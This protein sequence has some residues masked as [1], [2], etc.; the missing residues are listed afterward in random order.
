MLEHDRREAAGAAE[1]LARELGALY[2]GLAAHELSPLGEGGDFRTWLVRGS[3][4]IRLAKGPGAR[5]R[6]RNEILILPRLCR[7]VPVQVPDI[8]L[9]GI[10]PGEPGLPRFIRYERIAGHPLRPRLMRRMRPEHQA[11]VGHQLAE[12][13]AAM[14]RFPLAE[15][16]ACGIEDVDFDQEIRDHHQAV[17]AGILGRLDRHAGARLLTLFEDYMGRGDDTPRHTLLHADLRSDHIF[18][19]PGHGLTGVI[20]F[21]GLI[22]GDA[23]Y[24]L[25]NVLNEYGCAFARALAS[26]TGAGDVERR[27][28]KVR[29]F[30]CCDYIEKIVHGQARGNSPFLRRAWRGLRRVLEESG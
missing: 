17:H 2:P 3:H 8:N 9:I 23:D 4:V 10:D 5:R 14:H 16:R 30:L 22:I 15:A 20:D 7:Q 1:A 13:M 11:Q 6:L 26:F 18:H 27:M 21:G 12:F 19:E 28:R 24:D 25:A 29:L